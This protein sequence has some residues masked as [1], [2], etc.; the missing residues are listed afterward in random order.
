MKPHL[1]N[2]NIANQ[3]SYLYSKNGNALIVDP[4]FNG[5]TLVNFLDAHKLTLTKVLLTHGHYD[6]IRDIRL[7]AKRYKFT[8]YLSYKEVD[9][10]TDIKLNYANFF[11]GTFE[12]KKDQEVVLLKENSKVEFEEEVISLIPTPGHTVGSVCYYLEPYLFSGDTLFYH[13]V[14][15]TDLATGS[16]TDLAASIETLFTTLP[17]NTYVYPGHDR[18]TK[19]SEEVSANVLNRSYQRHR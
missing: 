7:L 17:N 18:T 4:G 11:G 8:L 14:G 1:F 3:N 2:A 9:F 15:R 6:H 10:L 5:E 12:L 16:R 13:S 19:L